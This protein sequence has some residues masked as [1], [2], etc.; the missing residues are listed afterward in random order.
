MSYT[1]DVRGRLDGE[2]TVHRAPT[3]CGMTR[4]IPDELDTYLGTVDWDVIHVNAGI[5]DVT[6]L[7]DGERSRDATPQVPLS[8]YRSI[9]DRSTERLTATGAGVIWA[10]T[11]PV[12]HDIAV[13]RDADVR[14]YNEAAAEIARAHEV[15]VTDLYT[16]VADHPEDLWSDGVHFTDEGAAVLGDA[17]AT[18]IRNRLPGSIAAHP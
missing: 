16:V 6:L 3:N 12:A 11:T 15:P 18:E 10:A 14:R 5:H 7:E 1:I 2:A 13:R 9:L 17:V 4:R 8:E